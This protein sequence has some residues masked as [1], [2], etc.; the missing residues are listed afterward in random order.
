M[1]LRVAPRVK[2]AAEFAAN[3]DRRS[4]TNF[5]EVLVLDYC[6]SEGIDPDTLHPKEY[7]HDESPQVSD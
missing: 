2:M 5:I 1:T 4:L 7:K 6:E 3:R